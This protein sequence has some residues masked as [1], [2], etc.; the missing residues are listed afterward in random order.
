MTMRYRCQG[1]HFGITRDAAPLRTPSAQPAT[2]TIADLERLNVD[3]EVFSPAGI[4]EREFDQNRKFI[5]RMR[6]FWKR[7]GR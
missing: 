4:R 6:E 3:P 7:G 2:L 5:A 1:E